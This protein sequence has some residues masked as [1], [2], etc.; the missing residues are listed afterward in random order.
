MGLFSI[1]VESKLTR[2][3]QYHLAI[4]GVS[5]MIRSLQFFI[6]AVGKLLLLLLLLLFGR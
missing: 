2:L 4:F 1:K 3:A 6:A 5:G